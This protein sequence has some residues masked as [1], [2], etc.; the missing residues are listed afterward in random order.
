MIESNLLELEEALTKEQLRKQAE[1]Q[2]EDPN[3]MQV[4]LL[5]SARRHFFRVVLLPF[6]GSTCPN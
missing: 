2:Y 4:I 5:W 3:M 6:P 1:E